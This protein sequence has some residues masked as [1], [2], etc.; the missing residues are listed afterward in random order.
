MEKLFN[1][2][3]KVLVGSNDAEVKRLMKTVDVIESLEGKMKALSDAELRGLTDAFR[4]RLKNGE[5]LDAMV[6][7][8]LAVVREGAEA[9]VTL[10]A[11]GAWDCGYLLVD[12]VATKSDKSN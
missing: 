5:T 10:P 6:P 12:G 2:I 1:A 3:K 7:E 4:A 11:V 9:V 8:A